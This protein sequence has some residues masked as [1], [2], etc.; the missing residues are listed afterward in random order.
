MDGMTV[1]SGNQTCGSVA[2]VSCAKGLPHHGGW[3]GKRSSSAVERYIAA[4]IVPVVS[5]VDLG[6]TFKLLSV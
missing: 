2:R 6:E 3:L 4:E 1:A 5:F